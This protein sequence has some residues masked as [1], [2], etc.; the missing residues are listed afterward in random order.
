MRPAMRLHR[1][2]PFAPERICPQGD[3][4]DGSW[5]AGAL[6]VCGSY[7]TCHT[8]GVSD[9]LHETPNFGRTR[10]LVPK[11]QLPRKLSGHKTKVEPR[12]LWREMRQASAEGIMISGTRD[13]GG[14][15]SQI[16]FCVGSGA[17]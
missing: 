11:E 2:D 13:R 15:V 9:T 5:R 3:L 17:A 12:R 14:T 7:S 10:S 8:A 16:A 6:H 1:R 4:E